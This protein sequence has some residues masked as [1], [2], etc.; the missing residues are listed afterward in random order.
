MEQNVANDNWPKEANDNRPPPFGRTTEAQWG[1]LA[2]VAAK[3]GR[4]HMLAV[5]KNIEEKERIM[6]KMRKAKVVN[7]QVYKE[8]QTPDLFDNMLIAMERQ[9]ADVEDWLRNPAFRNKTTEEIEKFTANVDIFIEDALPFWSITKQD[10]NPHEA[11]IVPLT[12]KDE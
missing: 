6:D 2:N 1:R 7:L 5:K 8:E 3:L 9:L 11:G 12:P 4:L 10:I